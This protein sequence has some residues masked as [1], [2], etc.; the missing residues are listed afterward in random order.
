MDRS[1]QQQVPPGASPPGAPSRAAAG[2][3]PGKRTLI[4]IAAL[5][6]AVM[7]FEIVLLRIFSFVFWHHFAFMVISMALLGFALSGTVL[8]LGWPRRG[9]ARARAAVAAIGFGV[10]AVLATVLV[11]RVPLAP[12]RLLAEPRQALFLALIYGGFTLPFACGGFGVI[13]LLG[14]FGAR[15][16]RLYGADL[17]GAGIASVLTVVA[18]RPLGAEGV[19]LL[20][21]AVAAAAAGLLDLEAGRRGRGAA[22]AAL[23]GTFL[24]A[25]PW[26]GGLFGLRP[27]ADKGLATLRAL[28]GARVVESEWSAIGR[29]DAVE[30]GGGVVWT[31]NPRR[32]GGSPPQLLLV[33]DGDAATPI[34]QDAGR[35]DSAFLDYTLSSAGPQVFRPHRVLV[36]GAGGGLDV[37]TALH[38]GAR[39]VDAVEVNEIVADLATGRF[40]D[41]GGRLFARREV[42][43]HRGEGRSFVRRSRE[44]WDLIQLSLIDTWAASQSG[45]YVLTEGYL[46]TVEAFRD[47]LEHLE[48]GG[49]LSL[50][51]WVWKVPRESLKLVVVA[52]E[53]L[54]GLGVERPEEHIALVG[55]ANLGNLL[56]K[57]TPFT[58]DEV[59]ALE[60]LARERGFEILYAPGRRPPNAF[61]AYF[62]AAD[63]EA[64][65][66]AYP[67]D[68]TAATDD[69]P[70][71]FQFGRWK[72]LLVF[73]VGDTA[74]TASGRGL[75]LL[76]LAQGLAAS[77]LLLALPRWL[78]KRKM[79]RG[80]G[81]PLAYFVAIGLGFMLLEIP[82]MQR[83][84]LYLG[85]PV[86]AVAFVLAALLVAAGAGSAASPRFG[87][88]VDAVFGAL[89]ATVLA[90]ALGSP[91]L[92]QAT[93]GLPLP[94]R[95]AVGA[96]VLLPLGFLLGLPFPMAMSELARGD[97]R[98][99]GWAWAAN[100]CASV[101]G[102]VLA[103]LLAFD[104]GL[105]RVLLIGAVAYGA[106]YWLLRSPW[107]SVTG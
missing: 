65:V 77:V 24:L 92:L 41:F 71:F 68:V 60:A 52:S 70:F 40:A 25:L 54:R 30:G 76:V 105:S 1:P 8:Q 90:V 10:S 95:F 93:L 13:S 33:I 32:V 47:Y 83:F 46:Y 101:L 87:R 21:A 61:G 106:A 67:H 72:D 96:A 89:I 98:L 37:L 104:L 82:L 55:L 34:V 50:T 85:H 23:A 58:G 35:A 18:I 69:A 11:S 6:G 7:G 99:V 5:A 29:V 79:R 75:L 53:A 42:R 49:V 38:H 107:E 78:G 31:R 39:E 48:P 100:G 20:W 66:A 15:V 17:A 44:R 51:R 88:R 28:P 26:S 73:G 16:G 97:G 57:P 45:A 94:A 9:S 14:G 80:D 2:E 19:V 63:P 102:P 22:A 62:A 84:T 43:L 59:R 74:G 91:W 4:A 3:A 27:G 86:Y 81:R 12:S 36:I 56:V 64:W 103:A